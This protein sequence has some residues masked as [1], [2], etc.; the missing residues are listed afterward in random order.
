MVKEQEVV[1][2]LKD[3][4]DPELGVDVWTLGLVYNIFIEKTGIKIRMTLTSPMCPYGPMIIADVK[5]R[6]GSLKGIKKVDV[7]ITF[8]PPWKPSEDVR[9]L[10]GV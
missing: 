6:V 3:V 7:E 4:K 1:K 9:L 8:N 2:V 10:L 5:Q